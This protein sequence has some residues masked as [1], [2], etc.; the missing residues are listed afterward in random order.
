MWYNNN[1]FNQAQADTNVDYVFHAIEG[2]VADMVDQRELDPN[3]GGR[4]LIS[5]F[6]QNMNGY[7][8]RYTSGMNVTGAMQ[9][10]G[11]LV[12]DKFGD[13][14]VAT[15]AL[16]RLALSQVNKAIQAQSG[17]SFGRGYQP[18]RQNGVI[19]SGGNGNARYNGWN[20]SVQ[21]PRQQ[22]SFDRIYN[23]GNNSNVAPA[24][25]PNVDRD[26]IPAL[27]PQATAEVTHTGKAL[28]ISIAAD[29]AIVDKPKIEEIKQNLL[30]TISIPGLSI[31]K[32]Q[33][34]TFAD[35]KARGMI[36]R[37]SSPVEDL[38][39]A[40]IDLCL[41]EPSLF[42]VD[43]AKGMVLDAETEVTAD[44]L[45]TAQ[46]E[47]NK[48]P[49]MHVL[50][51][52]TM[53]VIRTPF[54]DGKI[55]M[56]ECARILKE[57]KGSCEGVIELLNYLCKTPLSFGYPIAGLIIKYFNNAA[58]IVFS[59]EKKMPD[60]RSRF[61]TFPKI[62]TI[63]D[64]ISI[65]SDVDDER[66]NVWKGGPEF[67][68]ALG[69]CLKESVSRVISSQYPNYL[70][71]SKPEDYALVQSCHKAGL[72]YTAEKLRIEELGLKDPEELTKIQDEIYSKVSSIF[73]IR[74]ENR[75]LLH[76]L[77]I[78]KPYNKYTKIY[79]SSEKYLLQNIVDNY[80]AMKIV[81]MAVPSQIK[82]PLMIG[83]NYDGNLLLRQIDD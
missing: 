24:S 4:V 56:D 22:S 38:S 3:V 44:L 23:R 16:D 46:V 8:L 42:K 63:K 55:Y 49:H 45:H 69:I 78:V 61:L 75:V 33:E 65:C 5:L 36:L 66:F 25:T 2:I 35:K 52:D 20:G 60:G 26:P 73:I 79:E 21:E 81:D 29:T 48:K 13:Q 68:L 34:A 77:N 82:N 28:N 74:I 47:D 57:H 67:A 15:Q 1:G 59:Q 71:I 39:D 83:S 14:G 17:N 7:P 64:L 76:N 27:T 9:A 37:Q 19:W 30:P 54:E 18:Q 41:N 40:I 31:I 6:G 10:V 58:G 80:G 62:S 50:S 51:V 53:H 32:G 70:D 11:D 12:V 43:G 72:R